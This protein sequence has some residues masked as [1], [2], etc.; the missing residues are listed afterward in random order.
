MIGG[1]CRPSPLHPITEPRLDGCG[2]SLAGHRH[3]DFGYFHSALHATLGRPV[4]SVAALAVGLQAVVQLLAAAPAGVAGAEE[5][6]AHVLAPQR[7]DHR[8][9]HGV[10][11]AQHGAERKHRLKVVVH[12]PEEVVHHDGQHG[13]PAEHQHGQ[14]EH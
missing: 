8:V 3:G 2:G 4:G 11:Q 7:V 12:L 10:E 14:D 13:P 5:G 9:D 6:M 1:A